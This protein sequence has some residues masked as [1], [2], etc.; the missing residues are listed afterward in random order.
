MNS[1]LMLAL[2]V[3]SIYDWRF[4]RVPNWLTLSMMLAGLFLQTF[5]DGPDGFKNS[6][7][8][9]FLGILL[10]YIPFL[11]GGVGGGD[12][13]LLGAL[14]AFLG[15]FSLVHVFL[16]SAV[17]GGIFSLIEMARKKVWRQTCESLKHR[18]LYLA[19]QQKFASESEVAFSK[20]PVSIPYAITMALGYLYVYFIGGNL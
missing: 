2:G 14:G 8:G 7:L 5:F 16:A 6:I 3:A 1:V 4:R 17:I 13:K 19:L 10:L 18:L 12:V 15:P 20:N 11:L 9:L